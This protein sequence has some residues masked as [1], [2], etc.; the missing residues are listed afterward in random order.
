M[1]V[2]FALLLVVLTATAA[3]ATALLGQAS[4]T[5][6]Q[7]TATNLAD[8]A[9]T[10]LAEEPLSALQ[11]DI[12]RTIDLTTA[13]PVVVA[14][15][16][17]DLSQ[18]LAWFGT[19]SAPSLCVTG[20]P[21]EVLQATVTV[22]WAHGTQHLAETSVVNPPYGSAQ[23]TDGWLSVQIESAANPNLPPADVGAIAIV[24]TPAGGTPLPAEQPDSQ[25]CLYAP[26]PA[27]TYTVAVQG[28]SSPVFVDNDNAT[29]PPPTTVSVTAGQAT[30]VDVLYDQAAAVRFT[31]A[32]S[33]PP[34][35]TSM[36]VTVANS[37]MTA[38]TEVV[39]PYPA[40][41]S[42]PVNLFPFPS[43]YGTWYGD[44]PDEEPAVPTSFAVAPGQA[45]TAD[46]GGLVQMTLSVSTPG[47]SVTASATVQDPSCPADTFGLGQAAVTGGSASLAVQLIAETY[48]VTVTDVSDGATT[49]V[50][51]QWQTDQW[52]NTSTHSAY[53][54]TTPI[55]VS[56]P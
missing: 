20:N 21:P 51:L 56:V 35:A 36:P 17:F 1:L 47:A 3:L 33:S 25:G 52:V 49:T 24:I 41:S 40:S 8:Q 29:T 22:S 38:G 9:L 53:A 39:I 7:V 54:P 5:Q 2:A 50:D 13:G 6:D 34:I 28:P 31:P 11:P 26:E 45:T 32:S 30:D 42:G 44:C 19:G 12:N 27:G 46:I 4:T 16:Q 55:P 23:S 18:Y 14:G 48:A 10:N 43:G 15:N 37:G